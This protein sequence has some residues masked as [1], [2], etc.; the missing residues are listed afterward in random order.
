MTQ[1]LRG[2]T[3]TKRQP[4]YQEMLAIPYPKSAMGI[5]SPVKPN[6]TPRTDNIRWTRV[7]KRARPS[8]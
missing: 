8:V 2:Y 3:N 7:I 1:K 4:E 5:A 6:L